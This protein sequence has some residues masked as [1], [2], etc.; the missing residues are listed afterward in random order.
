M[1]AAVGRGGVGGVSLKFANESAWAVSIAAAVSAAAVAGF[2][3]G[4]SPHVVAPDARASIETVVAIAALVTAGLLVGRY[5][6][7]RDRYP[8]LL[9]GAVL[10]LAVTDLAFWALPAASGII[11]IVSLLEAV[12][13]LVAG[14]ALL[15][16][17]PAAGRG[18]GLVAAAAFLLAAARLQALALPVVAAGWVT[19]RELLGLGAFGLLLTAVVR[20]E[21]RIR[22][23]AQQA[24]LI[25]QREDLARDLH[26]GLAQ[27]L[28]V[29]AI[30]GQ[31]LEAQ[32][33]PGHP[34][35]VSARRA[36]SASRAAIADLSAS[37][38]PSTATALREVAD[39]LE[40]TL[41]IEITIH[42]EVHRD[43]GLEPDLRARAREHFVRIAREAIVNA[44]R[45]GDAHHVDVT[46]ASRGPGGWLLTVADDGS[47]IEQ[48]QLASPSGFGLRTIRA[49]AEELGGRFSAARGAGGGTVVELSTAPSAEGRTVGHP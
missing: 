19:P 31:R 48:S 20:D 6:S 43:A 29:I 4:W 11:R 41:G 44:A 28:A 24:A 33:G 36:L 10:V 26:D 47:G 2:A 40:A 32:L 14:G 30:H 27:D 39:E 9:L 23:R 21:V 17:A 37:H 25:A 5:R 7:S 38:A 13:L 18:G 45:H 3:V 35:T 46:L 16:R 12:V 1:P 42:D 49:R 15:R 22:R 8:L 34:L